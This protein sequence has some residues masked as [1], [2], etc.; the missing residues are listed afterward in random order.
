MH[1]YAVAHKFQ[2]FADANNMWKTLNLS[3][4]SI[5][6]LP[7][8]LST[9]LQT[10]RQKTTNV[11]NAFRK[12]SAV[13]STKFNQITIQSSSHI[14]HNINDDFHDLC[15]LKSC[16]SQFMAS[17]TRAK[18][19]CN[20]QKIDNIV[21]SHYFVENFFLFASLIQNPQIGMNS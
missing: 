12:L 3:D 21:T 5:Y 7:W 19:Y 10:E 2:F 16:G 1:A 18:V 11:P 15:H 20:R 9:S 8:L 4:H 6:M 14:N 13:P 17:W